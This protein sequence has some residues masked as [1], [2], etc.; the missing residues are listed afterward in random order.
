LY[1]LIVVEMY[2]ACRDCDPRKKIDDYC[3]GGRPNKFLKRLGIAG[4]RPRDC[5]T[6]RNDAFDL[7]TQIFLERLLQEVLDNLSCYYIKL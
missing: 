6:L 5:P 4:D 2:P 3:N 1:K 7:E